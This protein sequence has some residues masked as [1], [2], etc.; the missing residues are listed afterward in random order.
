MGIPSSIINL[1]SVDNQSTYQITEL[2]YKYL[3]GGIPVDVALQKAKLEFIQTSSA[4]RLP[5]YWAAAIVA[6][7]TDGF[8]LENKYS[9]RAYAV[10]A[11]SIIG[12]FFLF[13]WRRQRIRVTQSNRK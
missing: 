6:G 3:S 7:K 5:F 13:F 11:V 10:I 1:W 8:D 2:F 9:W 12:A 4:N